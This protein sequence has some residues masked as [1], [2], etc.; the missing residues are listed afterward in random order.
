MLNQ[1]Q[2]RERKVPSDLRAAVARAEDGVAESAKQISPAGYKPLCRLS[3]KGNVTVRP[4][5][6]QFHQTNKVIG[7]GGIPRGQWTFTQL[8][9]KRPDL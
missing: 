3:D 8:S 5:K 6:H 2:R 1:L 7:S 9:A 4:N